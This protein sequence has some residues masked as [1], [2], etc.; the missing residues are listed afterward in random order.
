MIHSNTQENKL[1]HQETGIAKHGVHGGAANAREKQG[2]TDIQEC[3]QE[4]HSQPEGDAC[5]NSKSKQ[6]RYFCCISR[7]RLNK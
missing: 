7:K 4:S 2:Q 3:C 1:T 6:K 5:R